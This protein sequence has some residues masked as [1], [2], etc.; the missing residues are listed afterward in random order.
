MIGDINQCNYPFYDDTQKGKE[1]APKIDVKT[2]MIQK[3]KRVS[4]R[5]RPA[6]VSF[7]TYTHTHTHT[8]VSSSAATK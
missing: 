1:R 4:M 8:P 5:Y 7:Y 2:K 3:E 6:P